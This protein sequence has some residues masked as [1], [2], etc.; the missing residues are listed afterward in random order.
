M[1]ESL[2]TGIVSGM[3]AGV[4]APLILAWAS[5]SKWWRKRR[6]VGILEGRQ[7]LQSAERLGTMM[8]PSHPD[9]ELVRELMNE[10]L[11]YIRSGTWS[12]RWRKLW[13]WMR[14]GR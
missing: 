10:H 4:T 7:G 1:V 2:V 8:E 9:Y 5:S 3:V 12:K 6:I 11:A 13:Y 14:I